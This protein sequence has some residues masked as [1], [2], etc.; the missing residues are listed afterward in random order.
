V[1]VIFYVMQL[2]ARNAPDH[3]GI[4]NNLEHLLVFIVQFIAISIAAH[5][6]SV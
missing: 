4:I 1:V 3:F 6:P 5:N 2:T